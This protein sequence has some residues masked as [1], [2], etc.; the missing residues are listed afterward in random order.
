MAKYVFQSED[1]N[2]IPAAS[3]GTLDALAAG[4]YILVYDQ[5]NQNIKDWVA[6]NYPDQAGRA[7]VVKE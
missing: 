3:A 1:V 5:E 2:V 7:L 6:Q 4:R